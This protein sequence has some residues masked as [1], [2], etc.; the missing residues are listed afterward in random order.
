MSQMQGAV[1]CRFI[2]A[3]KNAHKWASYRYV[4]SAATKAT[5]QIGIFQHEL[6]NK[7]P[8][9]QTIRIAYYYI[10]ILHCPDGRLFYL[11]RSPVVTHLYPHTKNFGV[12][13]YSVS[14]RISLK[15]ILLVY[16][17]R[18][19]LSKITAS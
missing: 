7:K 13:V 4:N 15:I 3:F 14:R 19:I 6:T 12:G 5:Q 17:Q 8:S 11:F 2:G 9:R 16:L 18:Y 1:V 10:L